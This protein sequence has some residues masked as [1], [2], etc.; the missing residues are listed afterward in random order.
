MSTGDSV[1]CKFSCNDLMGSATGMLIFLSA[2]TE[3]TARRQRTTSAARMDYTVV[4][5]EVLAV[6]AGI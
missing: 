4:R 2:L 6:T 3:Y 5:R 1:T